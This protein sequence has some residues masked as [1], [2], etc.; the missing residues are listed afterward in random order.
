MGTQRLVARLQ[1]PFFLGNSQSGL[2]HALAVGSP[3]CLA[4]VND[5]YP[6]AELGGGL[7]GG[8]GERDGGGGGEEK[9][10]K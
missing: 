1:A 2:E 5:S 10:K 8:P 6:T 9:G 7:L 4:A 3:C